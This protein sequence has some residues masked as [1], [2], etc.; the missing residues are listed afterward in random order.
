[1]WAWILQLPAPHQPDGVG[2]RS[3]Q[4]VLIGSEVYIELA[5]K[6]GLL[7]MSSGEPVVSQSIMASSCFVCVVARG[8]HCCWESEGNL[9]LSPQCSRAAWHISLNPG[10]PGS[11]L[12]LWI[13]NFVD[14]SMN[15]F[16]FL[17]PQ[18]HEQS[19]LAKG[20]AEDGMVL[21]VAPSCTGVS[22]WTDTICFT[23]RAFLKY[24]YELNVHL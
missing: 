24:K 17:L 14:S 4:N 21:T 7:R 19:Y 2:K 1:M 8:E 22:S 3:P 12:V 18:L 5:S 23:L 20:G 16:L 13:V 15:T 6:S 11:P 10:G 9:C